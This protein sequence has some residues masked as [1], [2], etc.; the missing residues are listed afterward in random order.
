MEPDKKV[1]KGFSPY[2]TGDEYI[3]LFNGA[4]TADFVVG[5]VVAKLKPVYEPVNP[6]KGTGTPP[7]VDKPEVKKEVKSAKS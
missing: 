4:K 2:I 1:A 5:F 7:E 6:P 3:Q